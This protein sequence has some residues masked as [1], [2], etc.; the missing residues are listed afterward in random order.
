MTAY[1]LFIHRTGRAG[2]LVVLLHGLGASGRFWRP[3][4]EQLA[5]EARVAC[6]DLLGF[7]RSPWPKVVYGVADHL[8]ALDS[9]LDSLELEGEPAILAGH[10]LGAILALEWAAARPERFRAVGLVSLPAYRSAGEAREHIAALSPLAR[11]TVAQPTAGMLICGL[12][13]AGRPLWGALMPFIRPDLPPEVARDAVLHNWTSYSRTLEN[14]IV[15]HRLEP[16]A[17]RLAEAG[18][19][20]RLLHGDRDREAPLEAI[21]DLA[22][23]LGWPL[24][25][26]DGRTHA[27]PLEAP[28]ACAAT[29]RALLE[30]IDQPAGGSSG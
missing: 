1:S 12:M 13:C 18:L 25:V 11:A 10:S 3:V 28:D 7:G 17:A 24:T 29:L 19:P 20:V 15:E 16:A 21:R 26:L 30:S 22:E 4:A 23:R 14:V 8:A 2:P 5:A 9:A 6:P 27:L